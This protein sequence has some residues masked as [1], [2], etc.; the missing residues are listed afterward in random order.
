MHPTNIN[1][2]QSHQM[3]FL[4]RVPKPYRHRCHNLPQSKLGIHR[5]AHE[6]PLPG[7]PQ[8]ALVTDQGP[9]AISTI[10]STCVTVLPLFQDALPYPGPVYGARSFPD[11][12]NNASLAS[13]LSI[14]SGPPSA[15]II[16]DDNST[17]EGKCSVSVHLQISTQVHYIMISPVCSSL[18]PLTGMC[19]IS[20]STTI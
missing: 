1:S 18:C 13:N 19:G 10:G 16:A 5:G 12:F 7:N 11:P 2:P 9:G 8:Q 3:W 20:S 14:D 6:A 15:N 4:Q 17:K